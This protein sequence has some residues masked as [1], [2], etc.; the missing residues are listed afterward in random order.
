[1]VSEVAP[2]AIVTVLSSLVVT[3]I[4]GNSLVCVMITRNRDMRYVEIELL[5]YFTR[6]FLLRKMAGTSFLAR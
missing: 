2:V 1:M 4:L 6:L 3:N 5:F